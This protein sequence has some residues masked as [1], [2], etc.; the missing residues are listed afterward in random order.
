[1]KNLTVNN[2]A[3]ICDGIIKNPNKEIYTKEATCVE[4]DSRKII[5]GGIFIATKGANVDG[6]TF[7]NQVIEKG[8]MAVIIEHE[9][10][11][12]KIPYIIVKDSFIALK[13]IARFY[14]MQLDIPVIGIT[15]SVGKTSTKE[16]IYS[17]L[18]AKYNVC[19]TQG[20]FNNEVGLPLT[21]LSIRDCH[22]IA[23]VEMGISDFGEMS[24]LAEISK[25]DTCVITNI[26][27]C[28][29][30]NL[31]NRE[32]V[33]RAKTECF[34]FMNHNGAVILNGDDDMLRE[35][36]APWKRKIQ[37]YGLEKVND[38][39]PD[40]LTDNGLYGCDISVS[41]DDTNINIHI[42]R[43]GIHMVY[44]ALAAVLVAKEYGLTDEEIIKGIESITT[45]E[46]RSNVITVNNK[47]LIDDCY[48]ANPTSMKAALHLLNKAK[49]RKVAILGDMF[50][51]GK[52]EAI[53]HH[54]VGQMVVD[55]DIDILIAVGSLSKNMYDGAIDKGLSLDNVYHYDDLDTCIAKLDDILKD[56]DAV[57]IKASHGM[58]FEKIVNYLNSKGK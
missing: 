42:S 49:S 21:I 15:G 32:G 52:N 28:H 46:G 44:N 14:R 56:G 51:L 45:T 9:I 54:E 31:I 25:P 57:L 39:Y 4:I 12:I 37:Y 1:M 17:A 7:V 26:G 5:E 40:E 22:E 47:T 36:K 19:K 48:N 24:R 13:I 18:S 11:D 34:N 38:I 6:H 16:F 10:D 50:E 23:V 35:V 8:A 27:H 20:N 3:N 43:P 55:E 29:L 58:H 33:I 2:I 30:E 41:Y 53:L